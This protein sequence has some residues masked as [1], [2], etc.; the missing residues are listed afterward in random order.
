MASRIKGITI[1]I[2]GDATGL[3]KALS[4]VNKTIRE[5]QAALKDTERL[6]KLN[7][8]STELLTQKQSYLTNEIDA[9]KAKLEQEKA[10]LAQLEAGPQTEKTLEQ[11]RALR[12]EIEET[13]QKLNGLTD[14]YKE[15]GSVSAQQLKAA[16]EKVKEV[17]Q[18]ITNVGEGLTKNV[19]APIVALGAASTAAWNEVDAGLDIITTKTGATGEALADMQERAKNLATSIPTDFETAGSAIGEV[20]TRFGLT[21]QQLEDLSGKFI[22]FAKLNNTDVSASIDTVQMAM[23]AFNL[24]ASHAGD[25]LDILN[26]AGQ[27]TGISV[28]N[29]A[30]IIATNAT[31]LQEMGL[32]AQDSAMFIANL[33][34]SGV[35]TSATITGLK[36]ALKNA[37]KEGKTVNEAMTEMQDAMAK[38]A[39]KTEA[40]QIATELFGSKAGPALGAACYEGRLSL[41]ALGLSLDEF[42]GNVENTFEE[43]KDPMDDFQTTLNELKI[44]GAD[45]VE[46]AAPLI[47]DLAAILKEVF[48]NLRQWWESLSPAMQETI[49]KLAA[50]TAAVGPVLVVVGKLTTAIG[51]VLTYA[52]KIVSGIRSIVSFLGP[53]VT[54][55]QGMLS[56]L[57]T[58]LMANPVVAVIGVVIATLVL[59]YNHCEWFRDAVHAVIDAVIGFFQ[60]MG[61]GIVTF[62]QGLGTWWESVKTNT[63]ET[64]NSVTENVGTA[65]NNLVTGAAEKFESIRSTVA[66]KWEALKTS[67]SE[68]WNNIKESV[69]EK[70][71]SIWQTVS[72]K[73]SAIWSKA[74]EIFSGIHDT[75]TQK[76]GDARDFIKGAIDKISSFFAGAK[77][78]LPHIKLPHFSISGSFSLNP[79]SIPHI[80]VEWYK[81]AYDQAYLFNSPTVLPTAGG[82][83]GF[84]DGNG[85]EIVA[86]TDLLRG[87]I[88]DGFSQLAGAGGDIIIP[89]NIGNERIDTIVVKATDRVNFRSGG[90]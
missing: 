59:L 62:C 48:G 6:L 70:A 34:K 66:E 63:A 60:S 22:K 43:T 33:E 21:G 85:S 24:D 41:D 36:T 68:T 46:A 84:G 55:I 1:E 72:D 31:A 25:M 45:L 37:T 67:T 4:G 39:T 20:N 50:I 17:G 80:G 2:D 51:S 64:W 81:K 10:A 83:K 23:A 9:T 42:A 65:W 11:Q 44:V 19:T 74:T 3:E 88:Q 69:A 61:E 58:F 56:G 54:A 15:F 78:E 71:G 53:A 82:M 14:E 32:S 47:K 27:D 77:L 5:N 57:F 29:L 79:P 28:D 35:D 38:A 16:G 86:G 18:G 7:P 73:F 13:T 90:R 52:P 49:I 12:R 8:G 40:M 87:M 89:V 76:I 30:Q 26:K 75:I